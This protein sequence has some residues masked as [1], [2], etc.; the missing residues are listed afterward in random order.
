LPKEKRE[1]YKKEFDLKEEDIE[2]YIGSPEWGK[3]F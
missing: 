1:R 2:I 3:L